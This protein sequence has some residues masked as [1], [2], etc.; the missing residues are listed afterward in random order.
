MWLCSKKSLEQP[1]AVKNL[2][3]VSYFLQGSDAFTHDRALPGPVEYLLDSN[4]C[5]V[6]CVD[7]AFVVFHGNIDTL[8][9][10]HRPIFFDER[11]DLL[12]YV[13]IQVRKVKISSHLFTIF[14]LIVG[15]EKLSVDLI[16]RRWRMLSFCRSGLPSM[17]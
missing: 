14:G 11:V 15:A 7:Y 4:G 16:K 1:T 9:V 3:D 6:P 8:F 2:S 12:L 10:K 5:C 13:G 17:L